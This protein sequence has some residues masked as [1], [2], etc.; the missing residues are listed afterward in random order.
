[1]A[2]KQATIV[3]L[4]HPPLPDVPG[5]DATEDELIEHRKLLGIAFATRSYDDVMC[6]C[7]W[8][9]GSDK[10]LTVSRKTLGLGIIRD[11]CSERCGDADAALRAVMI[12]R[13]PEPRPTK[14]QEKDTKP[15]RSRKGQEEMAEED[16]DDA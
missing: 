13:A 6:S 3:D 11:Y 14:A 8:R 4:E 9:T 15:T 2:K 5:P 16:E 10:D 7:Q 1:M 12:R